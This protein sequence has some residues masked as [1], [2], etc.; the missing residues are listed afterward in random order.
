VRVCKKKNLPWFV[1]SE[2]R[3]TATAH[4]QE[5]NVSV[6]LVPGQKK[7]AMGDVYNGVI[8]GKVGEGGGHHDASGGLELQGSKQRLQKGMDMPVLDGHCHRDGDGG[9]LVASGQLRPCRKGK[10]REQGPPR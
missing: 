4:T 7:V 10:R 3:A 6:E 8:G 5:V 9:E 2:S 1:E